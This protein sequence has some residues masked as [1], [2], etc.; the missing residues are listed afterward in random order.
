M[1][2]SFPKNNAEQTFILLFLSEFTEPTFYIKLKIILVN[3]L[4]KSYLKIIKL[5]YNN[6]VALNFRAIYLFL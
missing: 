2:W 3:R 6:Q 5:L 4:E 1:P